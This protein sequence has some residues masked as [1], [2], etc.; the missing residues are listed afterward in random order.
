[1]DTTGYVVLNAED[2][3]EL[4]PKVEA[5]LKQ[6]HA[7]VAA[8]KAEFEK[9]F[10]PVTKKFLWFTYETSERRD[11]LAMYYGEEY[12]RQRLASKRVELLQKLAIPFAA[13]KTVYV[14]IADYNR[15]LNLLG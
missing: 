4:L 1:M 12:T 3:A 9:R 14:A 11:N 5:K 15:L 13:G 10:E 2:C 8:A 6:E 7:E